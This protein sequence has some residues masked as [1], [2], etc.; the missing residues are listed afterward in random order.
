MPAFWAGPLLIVI[1]LYAD[2]SGPVQNGYTP[3][4]DPRSHRITMDDLHRPDIWERLLKDS[5]EPLAA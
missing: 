1:E 4:P 2:V 3:F 5:M